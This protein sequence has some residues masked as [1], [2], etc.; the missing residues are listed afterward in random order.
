[1]FRLLFYYL[2]FPGLLFLGVAGMLVSWIDRKVTARI[3]WRVG[4]PIL[5]PF[6]DIRKLL[7]KET[8][9]PE[10]GSAWTFILAPF[11]ALISILVISNMLVLSL[12]FPGIGFAGDLI[13][14]LYL[15]MIPPVA[16]IIGASASNNPFAALGASREMKLILSYELPFILSVSVAI[17]KAKSLS[18]G[19]IIAIQQTFSSFVTTPSGL[20]AFVVALLCL[21]AKLGLVPFDLSEAETELAGGSQIEYSG[22]LLALWKLGKMMMLVIGPLFVISVFWGGG[23]LWTIIFKYL[24]VIVI[25]V[26]I[27]N[28][29]PRVRV[30]QAIKFF[31][32]IMTALSLLALVLYWRGY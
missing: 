24:A 31:W 5:Q 4:P 17:L 22:P 3:Q 30:D 2:I 11:A 8:I 12:I 19:E 18:L 27:R 23:G 6:Y 9:L 7:L 29:N 15:L 20:I 25:T 1:M 16:I 26:L 21:Q 10:K 14:V 32:G 28:T 13:V